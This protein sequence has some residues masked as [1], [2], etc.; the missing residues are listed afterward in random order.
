MNGDVSARTA[1]YAAA[2]L[3]EAEVA[4]GLAFPVQIPRAQLD[5]SL[6]SLSSLQQYLER[7][8]PFANALDTQV[9]QNT[10][11]AAGSYLGEVIR[12]DVLPEAEWGAPAGGGMPVLKLAG[13]SLTP[14]AQIQLVLS[15]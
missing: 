11:L 3:G 6:A 13:E 2:L 12:R 4:G 8:R 14:V 5:Y 7:V 15:G 1:H 9:Y 10:L